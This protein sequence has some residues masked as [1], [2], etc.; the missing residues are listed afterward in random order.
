MFKK[1][2]FKL[3]PVLVLAASCFYVS[4][5]WA[6][7]ILPKESGANNCTSPNGCGNYSLDDILSTAVI[8]ANWILGV[9]G[10]LAL[11]FFVYGGFVFILSGGSEEKVREGKTILMNAIIGLAIVFCS[12]LIIQFVAQNLLG[13]KGVGNGLKITF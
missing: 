6:A 3:T 7:G 12:Y 11:L 5:A 13:I 2:F 10:A 1:I 8:V 9:V 4:V